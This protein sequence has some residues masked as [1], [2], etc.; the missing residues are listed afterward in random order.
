MEN[1]I[2]DFTV[3]IPT[4]NGV[5]RLP[6]LLENLRSQTASHL[7][8]E[9]IVVDNN[10]DD[11]TAQLI[12]TYQ[13]SW[14]DSSQLRYILE[15]EQGAAFARKRGINEARSLLIGFLDDDNLPAPD[16]VAAAY[17]FSQE[18][19]QAGAYGG[20]IHGDFEIKPPEKSEFIQKILLAITENGSEPSLYNP[21]N[22]NLPPGAAIVIRKQAWCE[23]V[24]KS[25][26][27][28]GRVGKSMIGGEDLE[29]LL[30]IHKAGWEIWYNPAMHTYHQIPSWRLERD[31]LLKVARGCGLCTCQLRLINTQ[32]WQK[33]IVII[34]IILGNLHRILQHIIKYKWQIKTNL[35][36]LLEMEFYLS[37]LLSPIYSLKLFLNQLFFMLV[38]S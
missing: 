9:I 37:N 7:R 26:I 19:P 12:K 14:D 34:K 35:V 27:F 13:L 30:Y 1:L 10:S 24:P 20:Q 28:K 16:W 5:F 15:P 3:A 21:A 8:W 4:Y 6:K 38:R 23:S 25:L 31:Y 11:N 33:P 18:H 32:L 29:P 17:A 36:A 22:L 2:L